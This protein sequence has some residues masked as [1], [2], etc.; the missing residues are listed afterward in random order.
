VLDVD[1]EGMIAFRVEQQGCAVWGYPADLGDDPAVY[2]QTESESGAPQWDLYQDRMSL[3]LFEAVL[4]EPMLGHAPHFASLDPRPESVVA[5]RRLPLL[6]I[7]P[8]RM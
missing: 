4:D 1:D 6:G 8:H 3:H 5:L 7:P 2:V